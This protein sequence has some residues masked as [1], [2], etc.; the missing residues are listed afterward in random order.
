MSEPLHILP[1]DHPENS[2]IADSI[3]EVGLVS[4]VQW[5]YET[6]YKIQFTVTASAE[7]IEAFLDEVEAV[8]GLTP[9]DDQPR[10]RAV[11]VHREFV[12]IEI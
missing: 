3:R 7:Q 11:L 4:A 9:T 6:T 8:C 1:E 5:C 12:D 10:G 2:S